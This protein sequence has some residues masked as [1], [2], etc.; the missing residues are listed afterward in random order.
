MSVVKWYRL[1]HFFNR[2]RFCSHGKARNRNLPLSPLNVDIISQL[3]HHHH[4]YHHYQHHRWQQQQQLFIVLGQWPKYILG[5][6]VPTP[7]RATVVPKQIPFAFSR[8]HHGVAGQIGPRM[9]TISQ[10]SSVRKLDVAYFHTSGPRFVPPVIWMFFKPM[11]K[12]TALLGGRYVYTVRISECG[13]ISRV[14]LCYFLL[15]SVIKLWSCWGTASQNIYSNEL[16]PNFFKT[17]TFCRT[18][19]SGKYEHTD[20]VCQAI[21]DTHARRVGFFKLPSTNPLTWF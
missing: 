2:H 19:K 13:V 14:Y 21:V 1:A 15:V 10:Q 8:G 5:T 20:T 4:H 11:A 18:A 3:H 7:L 6:K 16:T 9:V 12:I 17:Y